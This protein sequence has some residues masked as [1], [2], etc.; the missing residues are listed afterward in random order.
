MIGAAAGRRKLPEMFI[1]H[2]TS[3]PQSLDS[4]CDLWASPRLRLTVYGCTVH[5]EGAF[6]E[7]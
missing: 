5:T 7:N 1:G 4:N 2:R 6:E 3:G